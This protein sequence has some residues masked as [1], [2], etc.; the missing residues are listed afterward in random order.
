MS[1]AG[2]AAGLWLLAQA[3]GPA[4]PAPALGMQPGLYI[5]V[6]H[7]TGS[8]YVPIDASGM[9]VLPWGSGTGSPYPGPPEPAAP[10]APSAP[11]APRAPDAPPPP[12]F[13]PAYLRTVVEPADAKVYVDGQYVGTA[14]QFAADRGAL[15]VAPG[16]RRVEI[17]HPGFKPLVT[18]VDVTPRQTY[19]IVWR[20]ERRQ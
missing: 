10:R 11:A 12:G 20:L 8:V 1:F 3:T 9:P 4:T 16:T 13:N 17:A 14:E 18:I 7:G 6:P 15:T 2:L 5:Q 19:T